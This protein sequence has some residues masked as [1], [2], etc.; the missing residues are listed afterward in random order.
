MHRQETEAM[1]DEDG[2]YVRFR[3]DGILISLLYLQ[4]HSKSQE[5]LITVL[6]FVDVAALSP[7]RRMPCGE[8]CH[9]LQ[10]RRG[11]TTASCQIQ[12]YWGSL[13]VHSS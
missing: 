12:E 5:W 10:T 11:Q 13:A 7:T 2:L 6:L 4:A 9:S 1:D 3:L 8:S